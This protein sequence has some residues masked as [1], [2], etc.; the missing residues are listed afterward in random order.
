MDRC[1]LDTSALS[2]VILPTSRRTPAVARNLADYL[3][4]HRR[5]T[6]SEV[7]CYEVLRGLRKKM[8]LAQEQ[9]FIQFCT[10]S[11]LV[12]ISYDVLDRAASLWA[13]G[14]KQGIVVDDGDLLI[15]STALLHNVAL[16]TANTKHFNWISGLMLLNW[17]D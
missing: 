7:S 8:A 11:E 2:D 1:L 15:A 10:H 4:S 6:F 3:R 5:L 17:R 12:P 13:A 16:V 9:Q 14:R